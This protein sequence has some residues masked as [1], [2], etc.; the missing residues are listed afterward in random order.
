MHGGRRGLAVPTAAAL[1]APGPPEF[2]PPP[3]PIDGAGGPVPPVA[4]KITTFAQRSAEQLPP[5]APGSPAAGGPAALIAHDANGLLAP[6]G[7]PT[8]LAAALDRLVRDPALRRRLGVSGAGR[9]GR[10][11]MPW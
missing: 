6:G 2:F 8:A 10:S 7:D 9:L 3:R 11:A 4:P 1:D 5:A